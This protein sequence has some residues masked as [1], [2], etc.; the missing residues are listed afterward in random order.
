MLYKNCTADYS[1]REEGMT[2]HTM[3]PLAAGVAALRMKTDFR[4]LHCIAL[5]KVKWKVI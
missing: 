5:V 3:T 2:H 1:V 4:Y